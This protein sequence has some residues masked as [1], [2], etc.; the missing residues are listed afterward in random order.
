[1]DDILQ[2]TQRY[3]DWL[4][5][6]LDG[7]LVEKDIERKHKKMARDD[8]FPF[9][10]ATYWRWAETVLD[11]CGHA[12][13]APEV[14]AVG[15]IH[16]ENFGT[17]RDADGRLAWGVTDFDE[18]AEMPYVLDLIR[19]ATSALIAANRA[20]PAPSALCRAILKGYR[21]GLA[22]PRPLILDRELAWLRELVAVPEK[23]RAK[24]WEKIA[25]AKE[26][27]APPRYR[28]ALAE[29]MPESGLQLQTARRTAGLG[30]L[31]RPRWIAV[32]DW[33]GAPVVREAKALVP[34]AWRRANG[35]GSKLRC[36][37]IACG[38]HRAI[39][40]WLG[41]DGSLATRRL[42]PNN[43]KIEADDD[44]SVL[45]GP[46]MLEAMGRDLAAAHLGTASAKSAAAVR[47]DVER[48][49]GSWLLAAARK[50]AT[51]V[52][53]DHARWKAAQTRAAAASSE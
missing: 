18:A 42:S 15:D 2:S 37:E 31:G 35:G 13:D 19:L 29:A 28:R 49:K 40:P 27:Q 43:R 30:S 52:K 8:A 22:A 4:R 45:L 46:D 9:L 38:R 7:E 32:A 53:Q 24:F 16:L 20:S 47:R 44:V 34:S 6:Q 25:D 23:E 50:M 12:A 5:R 21:E 14:L 3:E 1:M 51:A 39:D 36:A 10:R 33:C 26:E 11:T 48:R 41:F 17:W